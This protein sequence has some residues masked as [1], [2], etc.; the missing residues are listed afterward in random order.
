MLYRMASAL[1]LR[2]P[3]EVKRHNPPRD[4]PGV[5]AGGCICCR[6]GSGTSSRL[7]ERQNLAG[8][9]PACAFGQRRTLRIV[10]AA[11]H[12]RPCVGKTNC[13]QN[14]SGDKRFS[15][16]PGSLAADLPVKGGGRRKEGG[17][18]QGR[19]RVQQAHRLRDGP[20]H[21]NRPRT[22]AYKTVCM[23]NR[24]PLKYKY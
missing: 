21:A 23:R 20:V 9:E 13:Y 17:A 14:T 10:S 16:M 3:R 8:R 22:H 7:C 1:G 6:C 19:L 2:T 11:T 15:G 12:P 4:R 24:L 18:P 5:S